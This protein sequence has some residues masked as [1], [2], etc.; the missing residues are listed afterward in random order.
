ML[1]VESD[2]N[3]LLANMLIP[4]SPWLSNLSQ[5]RATLE[6]KGVKLQEAPNR[7]VISLREIQIEY[8]RLCVYKYIFIHQW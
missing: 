8:N 4:P 2:Q 6:Q 5:T 1:P 7:M 3:L